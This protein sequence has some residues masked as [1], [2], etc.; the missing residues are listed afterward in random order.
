MENVQ[1]RSGA[2]VGM[3]GEGVRIVALLAGTLA[4]LM[5]VAGVVVWTGTEREETT[6]VAAPPAVEAPLPAAAPAVVHADVYFDFKSSRLGAEAV[7]VLQQHAQIV[8]RGGDWAVLVHGYADRHGPVFY[9]RA[10][11]ERRA[12]MVKRFLV[13]LG[14]P[15]ASVKVVTV[16]QDGALCD[17]PGPECQR[18][19]R[20]V[21]LE[22]RRLSLPQAMPVRPAAD[23]IVEP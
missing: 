14:V 17:D 4:M 5:V 12:D 8:T 2:A 19:N 23:A 10:L 7:A 11:A 15:D 1:G 3:K 9:N 6:P 21:H 16:G 18:L 13:E 22:M 20:R